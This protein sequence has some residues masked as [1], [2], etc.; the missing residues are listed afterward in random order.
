MLSDKKGKND[1]DNTNK[2]M[3]NFKDIAIDSF[4][5]DIEKINN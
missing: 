3:A 1:L 4:R 5:P 2:K